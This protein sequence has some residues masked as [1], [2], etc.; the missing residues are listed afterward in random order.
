MISNHIS[1]INNYIIVGAGSAGCVLANRLSK[2]PQNKVLLLEAGK[3]GYNSWDSWKMDMPSALTYNLNSQ[4]YNWDYKTSPQQY[5]NQRQINTPR[6]K[7]LGGSS[8]L[9]A[10]VYIRGH[11]LDYH[12]WYQEG[13]TKWSYYHCLPYFK[14][15][16]NNIYGRD[17]Y[18]GFDGPL[19]IRRAIDRGTS[20]QILSKT[21]I[22]AAIEAGYSH[23]R[24]MNG[25]QQEGFGSMDMTIKNGIR[26]STYHA[27]LQPILNRPNL[28]VVTESQV[29][30]IIMS[31]DNGEY[32]A[33]GIEYIANGT[34]KKVMCD[35][36]VILSAG[37]I[38]SPQILM[39][40]GIGHNEHQIPILLDL[41]DV[42][43]N[44]Q[45][46]LELYVQAK[47]KQDITLLNWGSWRNPISKMKAG[48]E[49]F[50]GKQGICSSNHFEVGGFIRS[51][52]GI[53]H[54]DIQYHFLAGAVEGQSTFK[55]EHAFQAHC[56][57]MRPLSRGYIK[58]NQYNPM[59]EPVIQPNYLQN[60]QDLID[61][62]NAVRLTQEIFQQS[63]FDEY[64]G[65]MIFPKSDD[66]NDQQLDELICQHVESAYHPVSTCAINKVVDNDCLVY[67]TNNLRVVDASV[68]PSLVSGNTNAATIMIAEK[69]SD[70]ILGEDP[71]PMEKVDYY[72][73]PNWETRQR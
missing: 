73:D 39:M 49:W 62:R 19:T 64:R 10:M 16:E 48:L 18:R 32:R 29:E 68:M 27:Y 54:P 53:K 41:P 15:L 20:D 21:F 65:E 36:E 35:N 69:M 6:G 31:K 52:A 38:N 8:S 42:G 59:L 33:T 45:D 17:K 28:D 72:I 7:I 51:R 66:L 2:N 12:R 44:L 70:V 55:Q 40:S 63:A 50:H 60:S 22:K 26:N 13:A 34:K 57:T 24:D 3:E 5:L 58:L 1:K 23:T 46:H 37:A 47:C 30:K 9:N 56:G 4:K 43:R 11:A 67:G 25:Y 61:L 71:L 14:K